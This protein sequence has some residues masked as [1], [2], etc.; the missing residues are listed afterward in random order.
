MTSLN[1]VFRVLCLSAGLCFAIALAAAYE[2]HRDPSALLN[3]LTPVRV[4]MSVQHRD[5]LRA[6]FTAVWTEPHYVAIDFPRP[7]GDPD[8]DELVQ[9]AE[10]FIGH[11]RGPVASFDFDWQ[12]FEGPVVIG[13]GSG[14]EGP[15]GSFPSAERLGLMFGTFPAQ[16]G[17][18]Y[19]VQ[20]LPGPNFERVLRVSPTLE[21]GVASAT[22]SVGLAFSRAFAVPIGQVF[23]LLG[24]GCLLAAVFVHR[25]RGRTA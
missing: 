1:W 9:R 7:I 10:S 13:H 15:T 20:I 11:S 12:M 23:A 3:G 25:K 14:R 21:V 8:V 4:P 18:T 2:A 6:T 5:G 19:R 17:R 24:S 16:T 22:A